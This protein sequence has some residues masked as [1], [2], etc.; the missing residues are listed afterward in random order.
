MLTRMKNVSVSWDD[1]AFDAHLG[2][3]SKARDAGDNAY[4]T[5]D[6]DLEGNPRIIYGLPGSA[7]HGDPVVDLG[8]YE[9]EIVNLG[10]IIMLR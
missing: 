4:A 8:C 9:C 5:R 2:A 6:I 1:P 7:R 3:S 10:T